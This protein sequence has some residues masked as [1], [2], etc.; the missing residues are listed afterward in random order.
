MRARKCRVYY[1]LYFK[2]KLKI[3][4]NGEQMK[5]L[6]V[7]HLHLYVNEPFCKVKK[8]TGPLY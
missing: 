7:R 5:H 3:R 2:L 6:S 1:R 4:V 8:A